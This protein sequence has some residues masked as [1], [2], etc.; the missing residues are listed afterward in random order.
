MSERIGNILFLIAGL[1]WAVELIPQLIK[2][3]NTKSVQDISSF[4]LILCFIAYIIFIVG[5]FLIK[6]WFLFFAHLVPFV[7]VL[8]LLVLVLKY[9]HLKID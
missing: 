8:I 1:L 9:R 5:C 2:T 7:N 3:M 4:F 6:N